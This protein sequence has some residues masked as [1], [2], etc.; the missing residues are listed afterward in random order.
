[1]GSA[2][3]STPIKYSIPSVGSKFLDKLIGMGATSA[4]KSAI[5]KGVEKGLD[6]LT[7]TSLITATH[8]TS[9]SNLEDNRDPDPGYIYKIK[10]GETLSGLATRFG[11]S[12][13]KLTSDNNIVNPNRISA[14][15]L[16]TIK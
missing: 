2:L 11:T 3:L 9:T 10:K 4:T 5:K 13:E 15:N 6:F 16:I 8:F 1:V 14:G 12:I 7:P